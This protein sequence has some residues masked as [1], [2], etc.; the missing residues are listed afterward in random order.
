MNPAKINMSHGGELLETVIGREENDEL[1]VFQPGAFDILV[2][3][4]A[5]FGDKIIT[6]YLLHRVFP[7]GEVIRHTMRSLLN[8]IRLVS[9]GDF[10]CSE[11][12]NVVSLLAFM[13]FV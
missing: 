4:K 11:V 9:P 8:S 6:P 12:I 10:Q 2:H 7:Q 1:P 3:N 13:F 5:K